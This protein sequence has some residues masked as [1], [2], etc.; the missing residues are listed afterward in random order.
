LTLLKILSQG[1]PRSAAQLARTVKRSA[2]SVEADLK[3]LQR[4]KLVQLQLLN[5]TPRAIAVFD[6]I[7]L[8]ANIPIAQ[9]A[10]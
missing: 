9:V 2:R 1:A 6:R 8:T 7:S 5:G 3:A 10:A 4:V